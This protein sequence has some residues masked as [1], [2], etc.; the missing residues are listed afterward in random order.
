MLAAKNVFIVG[1]KRTPFGNFGG[2]LKS[3]SATDLAAHA[4]KG[5]LSHAGI[6]GDKIDET[7]FGNV[8]PCQD[9]HMCVAVPVVLT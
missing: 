1:A 6:S 7:F 2:A 5:A 4:S 3:I 9:T 8:S